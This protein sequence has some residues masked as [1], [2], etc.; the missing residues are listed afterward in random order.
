MPSEYWE[1]QERRWKST[2]D[3]WQSLA[4]RLAEVL[5]YLRDELQAELSEP[6]LENLTKLLNEYE[7]SKRRGFTE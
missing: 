7:L 3:G 1:R 5:K 4:E 6:E 2:S